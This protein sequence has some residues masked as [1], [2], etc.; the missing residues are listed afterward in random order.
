MDK[1]CYFWK[2]SLSNPPLSIQFHPNQLS[3]SQTVINNL[4]ALWSH[5]EKWESWWP[6]RKP[7]SIAFPT[8]LLI[9]WQTQQFK[10]TVHLELEDPSPSSTMILMSYVTSKPFKLTQIVA[11]SRISGFL[12]TPSVTTNK[13][14]Y[15]VGFQFLRVRSHAF[16]LLIHSWSA[17]YVP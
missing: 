3:P 11:K 17:Y 4:R 13:Q 9:Y 10:R 2:L 7:L 15:S 16:I 12:I 1:T 5:W 8:E 6:I 14:N